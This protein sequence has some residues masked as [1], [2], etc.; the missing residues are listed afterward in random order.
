MKCYIPNHLYKRDD[1]IKFLVKHQSALQAQAKSVMKF[2]DGIP[3][4]QTFF[5]R[6]DNA[7]KANKPVSLDINPLNTKL[8]INTTNIIDSHMDLHIPKMWNRSLK[9]NGKDLMHLAEHGRLF[10]DII[11]EG[12]DLKAYV[13]TYTWDELG[14]EFDGETQGLTFESKVWKENH[15]EMHRR[16]AKG[17]VKQHSVGM[18]YVQLVMAV[19]NKNYGAEFEAWEKYLP[20]AVNPEVA[21]EKGYFWAV[22]EA[23]AIE[24]S[25]VPRGSNYAT[26]TIDNNTKSMFEEEG[27][28]PDD[29]SH[30]QKDDDSPQKA[31]INYDY[32][33]QNF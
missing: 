23:K 4:G 24:G 6:D 18:F 26:P 32:L 30:S 11:S 28:D 1:I 10:K 3:F 5:S 22:P 21:E 12:N 27:S 33:S 13:Q 29:E 8:V 9:N 16:Y 20:M 7:F 14:F 17:Q 15:E 25:A 19:N 31:L 2:A